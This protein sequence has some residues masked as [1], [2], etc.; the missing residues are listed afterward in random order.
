M[1]LLL[2]PVMLVSL[3]T[4]SLEAQ[5][6]AFLLKSNPT[7]GAVVAAPPK[8]VRLEFSEGIELAFSGVD[9][10]SGAN[11]AVVKCVH[12]VAS[13]KIERLDCGWD[14]KRANSALR[15]QPCSYAAPTGWPVWRF[16]RR[17]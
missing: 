17:R 13:S 3:L 2:F 10:T 9:V 7:V 12:V 15:V 5:A 6:H 1:R 16:A 8:T 11:A 4:P 14:L